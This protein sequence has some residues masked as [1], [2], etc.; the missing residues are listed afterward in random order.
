MIKLKY[1][2]GERGN[3]SYAANGTGVDCTHCLATFPENSKNIKKYAGYCYLC[4]DCKTLVEQTKTVIIGGIEI[5]LDLSKDLSKDL[6]HID[7]TCNKIGY[8]HG[9]VKTIFGDVTGDV[10]REFL[11]NII[12]KGKT[13]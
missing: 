3:I 13:R 6:Q 4:D 11:S 9:D 12:Y 8:I 1:R 5:I 7:I 2:Q 10:P